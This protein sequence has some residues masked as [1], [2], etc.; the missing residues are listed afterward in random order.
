MLIILL[1]IELLIILHKINI[2]DEFLDEQQHQQHHQLFVDQQHD[3][4]EIN[5]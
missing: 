3:Q 2:A 1:I 5:N 4:M